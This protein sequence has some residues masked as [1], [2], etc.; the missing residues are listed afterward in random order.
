MNRWKKLRE[1]AIKL[2][3]QKSLIVFNLLET[4]N[5]LFKIHLLCK[6]KVLLTTSLLCIRIVLFALLLYFISKY[7]FIL[8]LSY[9]LGEN[10]VN[11][12][13]VSNKNFFF[14]CC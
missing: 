14:V 3:R 13:K 5:I 1:I 8:F 9:A 6:N 10:K 2:V 12:Y 11:E 7:N 4:Q